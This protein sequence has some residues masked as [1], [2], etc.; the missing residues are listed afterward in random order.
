VAESQPT[1]DESFSRRSVAGTSSDWHKDGVVFRSRLSPTLFSTSRRQG[2]DCRH[3]PEAEA[4]VGILGRAVL[5]E[6]CLIGQ[7]LRLATAKA[8]TD[9]VV[10]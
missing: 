5:Y 10:G 3:V 8:M 1:F 4:V 9:E 2:S 6:G 7:R